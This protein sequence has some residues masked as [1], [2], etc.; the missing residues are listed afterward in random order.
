MDLSKRAAGSAYDC[1][2]TRPSVWGGGGI[3]EMDY[4]GG[5][6]LGADPGARHAADDDAGA[7]DIVANVLVAEIGVDM[8]R[9]PSP[10]DLV[11][12]ATDHDIPDTSPSGSGGRLG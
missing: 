11:S 10:R 1:R 2:N 6:I 8:S 12:W 9:F 4:I 7:S 5:K 3:A